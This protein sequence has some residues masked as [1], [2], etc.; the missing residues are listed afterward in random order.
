MYKK[1]LVATDGSDLAQK[2]VDSAYRLANQ[3]GSELVLLTVVEP[4]PLNYI[5]GAMSMAP[6]D[7]D[8]IEAQ[9]MD[10]AREQL[11]KVT[12]SSVAPAVKSKSVVLKSTWIAETIVRTAKDEHCDLIVLASHG[13][14]GMKRLLLGSQTMNV[15]THSDIAVLVLR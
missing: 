9:S 3:L 10:R 13:H 4:Y 11:Q 6:L 15:L 2:A 7:V 8:A 14:R 1:I 12:Q 5:E